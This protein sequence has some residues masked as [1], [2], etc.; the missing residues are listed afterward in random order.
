M[1]EKQ[2]ELLNLLLDATRSGRAVWRR[3]GSE[4]HHTDVAGSRCSFRFKHPLLAGEEGSDADAVEITADNTVWT[5]YAGSVGFAM[6]IDLLAA[7]YPEIRQHN[8]QVAARLE[9]TI[10]RIRKDAG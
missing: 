4:S 1:H 3:D 7:A 5:F 10:E 2:L 6:V 8:Q 9:E